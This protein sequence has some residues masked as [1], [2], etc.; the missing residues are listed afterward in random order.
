MI[1]SCDSDDL[2]KDFIQWLLGDGQDLLAG[3]GAKKLE[4]TELH[5]MYAITTYTWEE[6]W[7]SNDVTKAG[8]NVWTTDQ[9]FGALDDVSNSS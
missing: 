5:S 9:V 4:E 7:L 2:G 3:L 1:L 8:S 6:F